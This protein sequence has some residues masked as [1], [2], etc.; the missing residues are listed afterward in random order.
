MF[1]KAEAD[2]GF[3]IDLSLANATRRAS[4]VGQRSTLFRTPP[5][6]PNVQEHAHDG[7]SNMEIED[8]KAGVLENLPEENE[9]EVLENDGV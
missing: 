4:F 1:T 9:D 7:D 3:T 8:K 6:K 5:P 2:G